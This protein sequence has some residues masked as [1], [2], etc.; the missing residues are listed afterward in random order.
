MNS[1]Y[2]FLPQSETGR[3]NEEDTRK[4]FSRFFISVFAFELISFVMTYALSLV[5][6]IVIKSTNPSLIENAD[7]ITVI[8]DSIHFLSLYGISI[9]AFFALSSIL[10]TVR[11][12]K[13][14]MSFGKWLIGFCICLLMMTAGGYISS[15]LVSVVDVFTEGTLTNPVDEMVGQ[16]SLWVDI[17]FVVILAPI[18]EELMFR[19]IL[20]S[21]LLALGE[22]FAVVVS[23]VIFGLAH[24]NFF[25]MPYALLVG[26]MLGFIYVKTGNLM[27]TIGYHMALNFFGGIIAP[28]VVEK[29]DLDKLDSLLS[30]IEPAIDE[31]V[32]LLIDMIPLLIYEMVVLGL[33]T[34]GLVF[35]IVAIT[36]KQI[37]FAGGIIPPAKERLFM[38]TVCTVGAAALVT[39]YV[40]Y[41]IMSILP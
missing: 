34:V 26:L 12:Q 7:I 25:Q 3:L 35:L 8:E 17:L 31:L 20:C 30:E 15:I 23:G 6:S 16:T 11:P 18:L 28:W 39:I 5:A 4:Y 22:G 24:G 21:K 41:F 19:K 38:N 29:I 40:V 33:S 10:P 13:E 27:Y 36:K 32:N 9:P 1:K 2:N 37:R 14:K